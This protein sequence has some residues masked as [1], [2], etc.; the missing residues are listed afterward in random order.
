MQKL[1]NI[2]WLGIKELRSFLH[3]YVLLAFVIYA[4]SLAVISMAQSNVQELHNASIAIVDEDR[5]PLSRQLASA[6]LRP[7]FKKPELIEEFKTL[8]VLNEQKQAFK[9]VIANATPDQIQ[10]II[11]VTMDELK[12]L[13]N[14]NAE[15]KAS[16]EN[17]IMA[18]LLALLV[19]I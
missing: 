14:A 19:A 15:L 4:F 5:S 8:I 12:G 7:Y 11:E 9:L 10:D 6:F 3:D 18:F 16:I 1:S 2:F 13:I 17:K